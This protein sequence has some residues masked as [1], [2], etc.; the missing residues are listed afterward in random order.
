MGVFSYFLLN[1]TY[2]KKQNWDTKISDVSQSNVL[3][4]IVP[5]L[6]H[7]PI[8]TFWW[9]QRCPL[10]TFCGE[11]TW[12]K[13]SPITYHRLCFSR[14]FIHEYGPL[15][16]FLALLHLIIH[17]SALTCVLNRTVNYLKLRIGISYPGLD[18]WLVCPNKAF[19]LYSSTHSFSSLCI[20]TAWPQYEYFDLYSIRV[21][22][23]SSPFKT[24]PKHHFL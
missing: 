19:L 21:F 16:K 6:C 7:K 1:Q 11:S 3:S 22:F 17:W 24:W 10:V 8:Q 12:P 2:S 23:T 15:R 5:L 9:K 4:T 18:F 14:Y 20:S 13:E